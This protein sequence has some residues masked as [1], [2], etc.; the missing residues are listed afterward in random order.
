MKFKV[1]TSWARDNNTT[2]EWSL[3]VS[4]LSGLLGR[5][6]QRLAYA[7]RDGFRMHGY[8]SEVVITTEAVVE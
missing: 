5:E 8:E 3:D 4:G 2:V 1:Q 7:I 6:Q